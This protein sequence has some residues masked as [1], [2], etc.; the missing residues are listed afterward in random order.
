MRI[1]AK[2]ALGKWLARPHLAQ[3]KELEEWHKW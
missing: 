3:A 2:V 1:V